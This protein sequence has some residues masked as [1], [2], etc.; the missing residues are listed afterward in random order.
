VLST[1]FFC[2]V[3]LLLFAA[4]VVFFLQIKYVVK[5]CM[6]Y[7]STTRGESSS[8]A[9][10]AHQRMKKREKKNVE[11]EDRWMSPSSPLPC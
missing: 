11:D 4:C 8:R 3:R 6:W 1:V 5:V 2:V 9:G 10:E 7:L